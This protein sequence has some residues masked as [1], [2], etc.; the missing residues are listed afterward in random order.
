MERRRCEPLPELTW[1]DVLLT[2]KIRILFD[3]VARP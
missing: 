1:P 3:R 2:S